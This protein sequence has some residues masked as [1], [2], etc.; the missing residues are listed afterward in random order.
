MGAIHKLIE[1]EA[2]GRLYSVYR[3]F[4]SIKKEICQDFAALLRVIKDRD[5]FMEPIT[6]GTGQ[7]VVIQVM[8][9][10]IFLFRCVKV[11]TIEVLPFEDKCYEDPMVSITHIER[12]TR[13]RRDTNSVLETRLS[14]LYYIYKNSVNSQIKPTLS[15]LDFR[16]EIV[17]QK[18]SLK[19]LDESSSFYN[20][21][22]KHPKL[23][24]VVKASSSLVGSNRRSHLVEIFWNGDIGMSCDFPANDL[25]VISGTV[26][27][28]ECY[29]ECEK[30]AACTVFIFAKGHDNTS[31]C[32]PKTHIR[33][34]IG[35]Q[36]KGLHSLW[37]S[38]SK[39]RNNNI[40]NNINHNNFTYNNE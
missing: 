2:D 10:L 7:T 40:H 21:I 9:G 27:Q 20:F 25:K 18:L 8:G 16:D 31:F 34:K 5:N 1:S 11:N 37:N 17:K 29:A 30:V 22:E 24:Q 32:N 38:K 28:Q 23:E 14:Q 4:E 39:T 26:N 12:R 19:E 35:G 33:Q 36:G 6:I 13:R 3:N 15:W